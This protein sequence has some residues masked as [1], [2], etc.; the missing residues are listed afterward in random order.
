MALDWNAIGVIASN[1]GGMALVG[2]W[3]VKGVEKSNENL[4]IIIKSIETHSE[5]IKELFQ[6]RNI[7]ENRLTTV[8]TR[9]EVCT[10]CN[11]HTHRRQ[12][13]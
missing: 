10:H 3:L 4:P 7:H 11:S 5:S 13:D 1:I 8:E 2:K 12:G 9:I 6:S